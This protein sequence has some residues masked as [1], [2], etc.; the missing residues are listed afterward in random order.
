MELSSK[1]LRIV[2]IA[3]HSYCNYADAFMKSLCFFAPGAKKIVTILSDHLE[4]WEGYCEGD[5]ISTSVIKMFDLYYPCINL[6]KPYFLEQ[7]PPVGADY[8]FYF[9]ADTL[10]KDV[11]NYDWETF[12]KDMDEGKMV[13]SRHPVYALK[14]GAKLLNEPKEGWISN[15]FTPNLTERDPNSSAYIGADTYTYVISSF[16]G[17]SSET[18]HLICQEL[19]RITRYDLSRQRGYH[20]PLYMDEN[21]FNALAYDYENK[22]NCN[23]KFSV[24]QYSEVY[25]CD[26][27]FYD[28]VFMYQKNLGEH[29]TNRR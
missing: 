22:I 5:V 9:D 25:N 3:T 21:Y 12:F 14:D 8:V 10:F 18:M 27:D 19:M 28:T 2:Y 23:F 26:N 29:K 15:F 1:I 13:I 4:N 11:P 17:A 7:L 6:H 16:F 24:K 20:I